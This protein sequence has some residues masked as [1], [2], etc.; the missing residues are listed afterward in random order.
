MTL[1]QKFLLVAVSL[2]ASTGA[3]ADDVQK[4]L[5]EGQTA[6]VRGDM[7][8]AKRNFQLVNKADPRNPTAIGYLRQIAAY[9]KKNP[10]S[11]S[12]EGEFKGIV[13]QKIEFREATLAAAL[14]FM[15]KKVADATGGKKS[16]N[17]VLQLSPEQQN[18]PVTLNLSDIPFTEALRYIAESI[19]AK[20]EY[21][22]F[23][24]VISSKTGGGAAPASE[25][26]ASPDA[27]APQ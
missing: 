24:V 2:G 4:L 5:T 26:K 21:Q 3:W 1:L 12:S 11:A 19:N 8:T 27:P 22:K 9:E 18:A 23:A 10:G 20:V 7:A 16:V 13:I 15:K 25:A 14:D 6:Y 17:F